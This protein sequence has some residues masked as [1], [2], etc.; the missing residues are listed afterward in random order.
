MA[1]TLSNPSVNAQVR[2]NLSSGAAPAVVGSTVSQSPN[3]TLT[4]GSTAGSVNACI[5]EAIAITSGTPW[6][7][8]VSTGL[9]PLG[10]AAGM[11]HVNAII[12]YNLSATAGQ[13]LT[14]G[15]GTDP[16]L[17]SDSYTVQP[18]GVAYVVNPSPGYSVVGSSSDTLTITV[19]AGTSVPVQVTV[20]GRTA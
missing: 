6:T 3:T 17:G 14:V 15:A 5:S 16:V 9:D 7:Y 11:V 4:V 10:N 1:T 2:C 18:G 20:L 19:A 13:I 12:V 8:N